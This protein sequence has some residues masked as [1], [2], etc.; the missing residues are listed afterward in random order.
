M[1]GDPL[2]SLRV[3]FAALVRHRRFPNLL[4]G[5]PGNASSIK[6]KFPFFSRHS[7]RLADFQLGIG[8]PPRPTP[9]FQS[10][11]RLVGLNSVSLRSLGLAVPFSRKGGLG[12]GGECWSSVSCQ[13]AAPRSFAA[14]FRVSPPIVQSQHSSLVFSCGQG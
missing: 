3:N 9:F 14:L 10:L 13:K 6:E 12:L 1:D 8:L 11:L 7:A 4:G 2:W 5:E